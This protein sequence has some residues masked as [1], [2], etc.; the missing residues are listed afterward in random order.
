MRDEHLLT[1]PLIYARSGE[2]D[3]GEFSSTA[4]GIRVNGAYGRFWGSRSHSIV[5]FSVLLSFSSEHANPVFSIDKGYGLVFRDCVF[6]LPP[7]SYAR[8]G[9]IS[10]GSTATLGTDSQTLF[11]IR[12]A[13]NAE[14]R[15]LGLR[16]MRDLIQLGTNTYDNLSG[17]G[18]VV[19]GN[20]NSNHILGC[21]RKRRSMCYD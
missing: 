1:R 4:G 19:R 20:E 2:F 16:S 17:W 13:G 8:S 7:L 6:S 3:Y 10:F 21:K 15:A 5:R 9:W 14:D 11:W 12:S 18:R